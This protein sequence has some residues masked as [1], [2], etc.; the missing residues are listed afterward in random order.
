VPRPDLPLLPSLEGMPCP[1]PALGPSIG[2][3]PKGGAMPPLAGLP[4]MAPQPASGLKEIWE[5]YLSPQG[6]PYYFCKR[7]QESSWVRPA[8]VNDV[9]VAAAAA[10]PVPVDP[11]KEQLG[12]PESWETIGKT[13]WLRVETENGFKYFFHKKTKKTVWTCPPEIKR[14]VDALD[15]VLTAAG[16]V[17]APAPEEDTAKPAEEAEAAENAETEGPATKPTK[18]ERQEQR[19]KQVAEEQKQAKEK[20]M[21]RKFKQM[22]IEK[23][24]KPFD[25]YEKWLP[26][27]MYD[28]RFTA[29]PGQKA[30]KALFEALAKKI[31]SD[32]RKQT[33]SVKKSSREVFRELL[34]KAD[35]AGMLHDRP[36]ES[37]Q[38]ALEKR[39]GEEEAW[40]AVVGAERDRLIEEAVEESTKRRKLQRDKVCAEFR[41][42]VLTSIRGKEAEPPTWSEFRKNIPKDEKWDIIGSSS[43]RERM[44]DQVVRAAEAEHR[45][46]LRRKDEDKKEVEMVRKR[47]R[48]N[49]A[50]EALM[51][52]LTERVKAP[53]T[54]GWVD[55]KVML[56]DQEPLCRK[57]FDQEAQMRVWE[58]YKR[59]VAEARCEAFIL[60]LTNVPADA[61]GPEMEFEEVMQS[62]EDAPAAKA[63]LGTPEDILRVGWQEWRDRAS[64]QAM[65]ACQTWLRSC[66]HFR[67]FED[68]V[69]DTPPFEAL[70]RELSADIRFRRLRARPAEQRRLVAERLEEMK[71]PKKKKQQEDEG[72]E[73]VAMSDDE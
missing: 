30:R 34:A 47:R 41:T 26:K 53:F 5:E 62:V 73:D 37:A 56:K 64:E 43:E 20:D 15:G 11:V 72:G 14:E 48:L 63:F 18:A 12:E 17:E 6:A 50:E 27:L 49:E 24:V 23:G 39:F 4:V 45:K 25:K 70:I 31:D 44:Y 13:G 57:D 69:P 19:E 59:S 3:L 40:D 71:D 61:I 46:R 67:G 2:A 38:R 54:V 42:L 1:L 7:T 32:K 68:A 22:L 66:E 51:Q 33:A 58:D 36:P 21:L 29:V 35:E 60:F 16:L 9:V 55:V 10:E 65:Q 8:G 52:L 28:E